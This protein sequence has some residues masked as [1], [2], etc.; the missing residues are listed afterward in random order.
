MG[1]ILPEYE[2]IEAFAELLYDEERSSYSFEEILM[3]SSCLRISIHKLIKELAGYGLKYKG[4][5]REATVRG[6]QSNDHNRWDGN[7]CG[8]GSGYEQISG[9]AGRKG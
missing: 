9:F 1:E 7:P 6:F 3:L 4:R 8:G 5:P 2:S